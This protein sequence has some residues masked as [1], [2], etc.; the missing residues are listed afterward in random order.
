MCASSSGKNNEMK[1]EVEY[2][3]RSRQLITQLV[4][5]RIDY[6]LKDETRVN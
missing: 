6:G 1:Q 5:A 2:Q 4:T 3:C